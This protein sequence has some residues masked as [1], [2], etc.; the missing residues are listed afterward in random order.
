[1]AEGIAEFWPPPS[2]PEFQGSH[3]WQQGTEKSSLNKQRLLAE[4]PKLSSR[5]P[6]FSSKTI[7]FTSPNRVNQ[8][9]LLY[10]D[11]L[12]IITGTDRTFF[13]NSLDNQLQAVKR[14]PTKPLSS[15]CHT[16]NH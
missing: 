15:Q 5:I 8:G 3:Y 6:F 1:L 13:L 16:A 7:E 14:F 12:T 10:T 11:R 2:E 4:T 9:N